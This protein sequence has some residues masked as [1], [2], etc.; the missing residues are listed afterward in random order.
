ML[1]DSNDE[2]KLVGELVFD[3]ANSLESTNETLMLLEVSVDTLLAFIGLV[4][5][6][7]V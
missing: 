7:G 6:K 1:V 2:S 5:D 3:E 4:E